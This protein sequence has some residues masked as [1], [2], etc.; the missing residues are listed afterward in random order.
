MLPYERAGELGWLMRRLFYVVL[1][2]TAAACGGGSF[3]FDD[4]ARESGE[5]AQEYAEGRAFAEE[6]KARAKDD[7]CL[8]DILAGVPAE[9]SRCENGRSSEGSSG[10]SGVTAITNGCVTSSAL[11][12]RS[13]PGTQYSTVGYLSKGDCRRL[14][15]RS[16]DGNWAEIK[17]GWVSVSYLDITGSLSGLSVDQPVAPPPP[18]PSSSGQSGCPNGC[19]YHPPGCNIKGNISF[20]SDEKIYHVPGQEYYDETIIRPDYGERW[21]C[22]EAEAIANGWRKAEV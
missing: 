8:E 15:G 11:T 10:G 6:L 19:T 17:N 1:V 20:N 12:I 21:F 9:Y 3:P 7:P 18:P 4:S 22:T 13:G 5:L 16:S 14:L 2:V